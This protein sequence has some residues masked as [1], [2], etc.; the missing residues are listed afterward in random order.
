MY[1]TVKI[2]SP[3][4][5]NLLKRICMAHAV[6]QA[7]GKKWENAEHPYDT[8]E[9]EDSTTRLMGVMAAMGPLHATLFGFANSHPDFPEGG[10]LNAVS[11][12]FSTCSDG[13]VR[14]VLYS[15]NMLD[16]GVAARNIIRTFM[17]HTTTKHSWTMTWLTAD[18]GTLKETAHLQQL[19]GG[20][21]IFHPNGEE[22][23]DIAAW[24]LSKQSRSQ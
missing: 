13:N 8:P 15:G 5:A 7:E 23:L 20:A 14:V 18:R 11:S 9:D 12:E 6:L 4:D 2:L 19:N 3:E 21:T 24:L 16:D 22:N 17:R 1:N 10:V